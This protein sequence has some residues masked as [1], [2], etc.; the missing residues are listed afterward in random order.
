VAT[1]ITVSDALAYQAASADA[2]GSPLYAT[3]LRGLHADHDA[4]GL[5]A[6]LLRDRSQRPVHDAIALRLLGGVHRIVLE[7]RAPALAE[8]YPSVGGQAGGD[9]T[10]AF[11][12]V[13]EE[14]RGEVDA[15]LG[16]NVQTNEVGRAAALV[17]GFSR[18]ARR[19][20]LP[21]RLRE[22]GSS[23]GLLLNWDRYAYDTGHSRAGDAD[24]PVRFEPA[25]WQAPPDL[26][27]DCVVLDRRGCD[28]HPI[29]PTS[30]DGRL[31]LLS[32][33]WPDQDAR[34]LRLRAALD[35]AARH[36]VTIDAADAGEWV[37]HELASATPGLATVVHHSI[38]LQ[39]LSPASLEHLRGALRAAGERATPDAPLAW[40]RMEPAGPVADIR[41]TTWPGGHEEVAGTTGYHGQDVRWSLSD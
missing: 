22:V 25:S 14:H 18:I 41:L 1:P 32:F 5:T 26:S 12:A 10:H 8:H 17:G 33:V 19:T 16:R 34:F 37:E 21:L 2:L 31:T 23:A 3:L 13:C 30:E 11:L 7:G 36:P 38:V 28:V 24:S 6:D 29:D 27:G 40:L 9:P 39:Y 20:Q 35:V 15:S 4:G